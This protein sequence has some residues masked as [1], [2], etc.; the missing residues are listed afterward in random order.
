M[1][2]I[3]DRDEELWLHRPSLLLVREEI[4]VLF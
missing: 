2:G 3:E 1:Y 4:L